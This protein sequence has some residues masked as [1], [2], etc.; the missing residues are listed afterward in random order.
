[1]HQN[2]TSENTHQHSPGSNPGVCHMLA[3]F[4]LVLNAHLRVFSFRHTGFPPST[5]TSMQPIIT[6]ELQGHT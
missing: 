3:D 4:V 1:M 6:P 5:K 2:G